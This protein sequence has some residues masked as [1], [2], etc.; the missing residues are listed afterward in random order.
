M[1]VSTLLTRAAHRS[2]AAAALAAACALTA[3]AAASAQPPR[4]AA[5]TCTQVSVPLADPAGDGAVVRG[6]LCRPPQANDTVQVLLSGLT[7]DSRYWTQ[8]PAPG[9]PSYTADAHAR[10]FTT[11]TL[12]RLGTGRSSRPPAD[13]VT[14]TTDVDSVHQTVTR[15]RTGLAGH[16][17]THIVLVGH[18]YGAGEALAESSLHDDVT[19]VVLSGFAHAA[20]PKG[21]AILPAMIPAAQ[22]PVL[23]PTD[24]PDGYLT[25]RQGSRADLFYAPADA[26]PDTITRDELTKSTMT[27]GQRDS[28]SDPYAPDLAARQKAPV[29]IALGSADALVCGGPYL[30]CSSPEEIRTFERYLF[31]GDNR[32]DA[33]VLPGAGHS[34]NLHRNASAWHT[35]SAD[36]IE[37][38]TG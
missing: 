8:P 24:P 13:Q 12:D 27:T 9:Q 29:L 15:L 37:D 33:Y 18:S 10:G 7:Y 32:L 6:E 23:A 14:F 34:I 25:T 4:P 36:W 16:T 35:R 2:A 20:G 28:L 21:D 17:F 30:A 11:L 3:P 1:S 38:V 19:A 22:D 31:T 5:V 26:A